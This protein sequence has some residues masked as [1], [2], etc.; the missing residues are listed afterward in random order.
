[1]N[2]K[3]WIQL[4]C[5]VIKKT[6]LAQL[7]YRHWIDITPS[8][9]SHGMEC[10]VLMSVSAYI[11]RQNKEFFSG[12]KLIKYPYILCTIIYM[13]AYILYFTLERKMIIVGLQII[14]SRHVFNIHISTYKVCIL[15]GA[16]QQTRYGKQ[17]IN[18][19]RFRISESWTYILSEHFLKTKVGLPNLGTPNVILDIFIRTGAQKC[20]PFLTHSTHISP[21]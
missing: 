7:L 13:L 20:Q 3:E 8:P 17:W 18:T 1:M 21:K 6:L 4:W 2:G 10:I 11:T 9:D 19:Q 5:C 15:L 16:S 12:F 14:T